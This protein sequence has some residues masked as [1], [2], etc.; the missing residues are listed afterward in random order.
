MRHRRRKGQKRNRPWKSG[1]GF[2]MENYN[3][4][5]GFDEDDENCMQMTLKWR[6]KL[7]KKKWERETGCHHTLGR[8]K[9]TSQCDQSGLFFV[10]PIIQLIS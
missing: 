6:E 10:D 2:E 8:V 9:K 5:G 7:L 3:L 1:S 4:L